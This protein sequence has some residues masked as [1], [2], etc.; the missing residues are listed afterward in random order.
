MLLTEVEDRGEQFRREEG[1]FNDGVVQRECRKWIRR[2]QEHA[3]AKGKGMLGYCLI[4]YQL[5]E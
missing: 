3:C 2:I 4:I 5:L 1:G